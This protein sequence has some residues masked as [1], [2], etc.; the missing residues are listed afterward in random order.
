MLK[1]HWHRHAIVVALTIGAMLATAAAASATQTGV[2]SGYQW[3][4]AIAAASSPAGAATWTFGTSGET[5]TLTN[6]AESCGNGIITGTSA[7]LEQSGAGP[8][9]TPA[10]PSNAA[11]MADCILTSSSPISRVFELSKP[12]LDPVFY[13]NNLD[14]STLNF[15]PGPSG[16]PIAL[17]DLLSD[18][19][20]SVTNGA[21]GSQIF[22]NYYN[23][24]SG[25]SA[26]ETSGCGSFQ[27]AEN[28]GSVTDFTMVDSTKGAADDGWYWSFAF[29]TAVLTKSFLPA[30]VPVGQTSEL[31]FTIDNSSATS[32]SPMAYT[33]NLPSGLTLADTT[34]S[35]N[36]DCGTESI[37][38]QQGGALA[39]GDTGVGVTNLVLA[40][41]TTCTITVD[42]T[43]QS[44]GS[45]VNG[46]SN[47]TTSVGNL[48]PDT[49]ATLTVTKALPDVTCTTP[50]YIFDTGDN[51]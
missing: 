49:S 5:A 12:L 42:V 21:T 15:N 31:T 4:T 18:A 39:A 36:G 43:S 47:I 50:G 24:T 38:D 46:D 26:G 17:T 28:S 27:M 34:T 13:L 22:D 8:Y 23:A 2:S 45:Y 33:D 30:S 48:V 10:P 16:G 7:N 19:T 9:L 11:S 3:P 14:G 32:L 6:A 51:G 37:T 25:C 20:A 40:P 29:P 35:D 41:N 1:P 44:S